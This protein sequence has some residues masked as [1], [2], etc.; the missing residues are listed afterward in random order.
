MTNVVLRHQSELGS[1][2]ILPP[3][4]SVDSASSLCFAVSP[5]AREQT[6]T[7]C[8][9]I[10]FPLTTSEVEIKSFMI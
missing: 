1:D 5:N 4:R 2:H 8:M 7:Y 6:N 10:I 9:C 3:Q